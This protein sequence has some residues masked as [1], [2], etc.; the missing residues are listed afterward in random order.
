MPCN[1]PCKTMQI[2]GQ[3]KRIWKWDYNL[4]LN[5]KQTATNYH[6]CSFIVFYTAT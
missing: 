3:D 5:D 2:K 6:Y 4:F 1:K